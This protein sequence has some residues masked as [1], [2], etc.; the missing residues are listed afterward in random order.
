MYIKLVYENRL[1][2]TQLS[3]QTDG[4]VAHL[5]EQ[6]EEHVSVEGALMGLVHDYSAIVVQVRLP[7]RFPQKNP[8]RHVFYYGL[9]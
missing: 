3:G 9:L 5:S 1:G 6:T 4:D 7:Q 2:A 8:I